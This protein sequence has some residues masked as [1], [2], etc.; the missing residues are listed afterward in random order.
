M[1][2]TARGDAYM[3]QEMD[4]VIFETQ[5]LFFLIEN[6]KYLKVFWPRNRNEN[7][8][9]KFKSFLRPS[10]PTSNSRHYEKIQNNSD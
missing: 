6:L 3:Q 8:G 2:G 9:R 5:N 4:I 7:S 1:A 10:D